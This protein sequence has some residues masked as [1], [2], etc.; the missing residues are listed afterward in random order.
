[1]IVTGGAW[2]GVQQ[3]G[4]VHGVWLP[5]VGRRGVGAPCRV[6]M[7]RAAAG[8]TVPRHR[9]ASC[10]GGSCHHCMSPGVASPGCCIAAQC[11][12]P[13]PRAVS[14]CSTVPRVMSLS[15][16]VLWRGTGTLP[17]SRRSTPCRAMECCSV[18]C[19]GT[20]VRLVS[21]SCVAVASRR[22]S[23]L[24]CRRHVA[25]WLACCVCPSCLVSRVTLQRGAAARHAA[26]TLLHT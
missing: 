15:H 12:M 4:A 11:R 1:M 23:H 16:V 7:R 21:P 14:C 26:A 9:R 22:V 25:L 18:S 3:H 10:Y 17:V 8:C 24:V 2:R 20:V 19:Y 5:D 6:V 13:R